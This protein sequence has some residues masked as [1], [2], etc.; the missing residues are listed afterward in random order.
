MIRL[1]CGDRVIRHQLQRLDKRRMIEIGHA[2]GRAH[3]HQ[4]RRAGCLRQRHAQRPR[5]GQREAQ[6]F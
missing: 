6:V 1:A 2:I 5:A 4:L 3:L